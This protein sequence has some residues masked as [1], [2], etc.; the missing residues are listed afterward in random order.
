MIKY[1]FTHTFMSIMKT[2]GNNKFWQGYEETETSSAA[3]RKIELV[4]FHDLLD[5][6]D[7][8]DEE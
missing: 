3:S 8:E 6:R 4:G 2:M 7:E 5:V 1:H